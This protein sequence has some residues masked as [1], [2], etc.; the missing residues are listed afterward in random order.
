MELLWKDLRF[1]VRMLVRS[2]GFT[3]AAVLTLG[4]GIGAN[5]AIFSVVNGVL[6]K[7]LPYPQAERL[8]RLWETTPSF[9]DMSI[10]YPDFLDWREQV[11]SLEGLS[12]YRIQGYNPT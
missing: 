8:I 2:P 10:S 1:A 12:A 3:V 6:L 5:S 9:P 4:L 7:P 11:Q